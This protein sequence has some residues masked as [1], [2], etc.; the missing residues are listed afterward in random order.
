MTFQTDKR[1]EVRW[2]LIS[3][4]ASQ[5]GFIDGFEQQFSNRPSIR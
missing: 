2:Y 3:E 5:I 4:V 1:A